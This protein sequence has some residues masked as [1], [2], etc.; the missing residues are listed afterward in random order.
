M[1]NLKSISL[2]TLAAAIDNIDK[3]LSIIINTN[4]KY[5]CNSIIANIHSTN[6]H[7]IDQICNTKEEHFTEKNRKLL[8]NKAINVREKISILKEIKSLQS[9]I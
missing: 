6:E 9:A 5:L 2:L 8:L 3:M 7:L 4:H 1:S